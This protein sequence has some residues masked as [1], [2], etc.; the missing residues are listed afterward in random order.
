MLAATVARTW[1]HIQKPIYSQRT[2][3]LL[4]TQQLFPD[5]DM[6]DLIALTGE[7]GHGKDS[8]ANILEEHYGFSRLSFAAP[9][10]DAVS[11]LFDIPREDMEDRVKKEEVI[12]KWGRSSRQIN[13]WLGTDVLRK[14]IRD[15]F[16]LVLMESRLEKLIAEGRNIVI[17]DCRFDNEAIFTT[18]QAQSNAY[19]SGVWKI[20]AS[21]RLKSTKVLL[22]CTALHSSEAG[23]APH[24]ITET[25]D[26]NGSLQELDDL[27]HQCIRRP[28]TT[29]INLHTRKQQDNNRNKGCLA[30]LRPVK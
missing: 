9:M 11:I 26:N 22:G 7:A 24:L 12:E 25:I 16:F 18:A 14:N 27:V 29:S 4:Q 5:K 3:I 19:N 15:D 13:Q 17:T 10:K 1:H 23:I 20:D 2:P 30:C 28:P 21:K 6:P 8:V